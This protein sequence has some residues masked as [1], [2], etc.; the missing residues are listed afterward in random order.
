MEHQTNYPY[1]NTPIPFMMQF[2]FKINGNLKAIN[3]KFIKRQLIL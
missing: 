3:S 2:T 1:L